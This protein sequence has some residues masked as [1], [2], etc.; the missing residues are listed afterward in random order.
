MGVSAP[1]HDR[2]GLTGKADVVGVAPLAAQ[3]AGILGAGHRLT[4]A[5]FGERPVMRS[6]A[7]VHY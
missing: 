7:N 2:V 5:E 6:V 1:H 3:Q 4:D